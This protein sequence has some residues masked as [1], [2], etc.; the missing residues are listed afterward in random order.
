MAEPIKDPLVTTNDP[1]ATDD[2]NPYVLQGLDEITAW[3]R[4]SKVTF[5]KLKENGLPAI[6]INNRWY[7]TRRRSTAGSSRSPAHAWTASSRTRN[8]TTPCARMHSLSASISPCPRGNQHCA[9]HRRLLV[10]MHDAAQDTGTGAGRILV[11]A[12]LR[13]PCTGPDLWPSLCIEAGNTSKRGGDT[14]GST[15]TEGQ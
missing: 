5:Y 2:H 7:A 15:P 14:D 13:P 6:V 9:V 3:L 4:V 11:A 1:L 8:K 12:F 10:A